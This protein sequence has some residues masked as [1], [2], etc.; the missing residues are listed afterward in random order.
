MMEI[1]MPTISIYLPQDSW[2]FLDQISKNKPSAL[3]KTIVEEWI[4]KEK[5]TKKEK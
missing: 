1:I 5:G 4:E 3:I 2:R